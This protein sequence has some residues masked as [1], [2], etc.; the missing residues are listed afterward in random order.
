[1]TSGGGGGVLVR[2]VYGTPLV[3]PTVLS[4]WAVKL[5]SGQWCT[6]RDR[7]KDTRHPLGERPFD[8]TLDLVGT[9]DI[10]RIRELWLLCPPTTFS[11]AGSTGHLLIKERGT[12]FQFKV[13]S[14]S[15]LSPL[16]HAQRES[17]VIGRIDEKLS[18]R[19]TCF[20]YDH[21]WEVLSTPYV[22]SIHNFG[23]WR[24]GIAPI[25]NLSQEVLGFDLS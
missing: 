13:K 20:I 19:C 7:V 9:G 17:Q 5:S 22:T 14:T 12:P 16:V 8:W 3:I 11:P 15:G 23:T 25:T 21:E 4:Y 2:S 24:P 1:M 10:A 18:G 6:E